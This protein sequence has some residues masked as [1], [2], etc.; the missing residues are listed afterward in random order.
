MEKRETVPY[1]AWRATYGNE[2]FDRASAFAYTLPRVKG[3]RDKGVHGYTQAQFD[4][5]WE[6]VRKAQQ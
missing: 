1:P 2:A 5:A 4:L 3:E 6:S